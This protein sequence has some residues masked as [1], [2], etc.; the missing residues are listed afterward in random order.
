MIRNTEVREDMAIVYGSR[1]AANCR[2][3]SFVIVILT[4]SLADRFSPGGAR[5]RGTRLRDGLA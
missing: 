2:F 4:V 3:H 5:G 1:M